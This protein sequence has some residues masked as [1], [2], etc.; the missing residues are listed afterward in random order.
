M[1]LVEN[2]RF[3]GFDYLIVIFLEATCD[4]NLQDLQD[5]QVTKETAEIIEFA[6]VVVDTSNLEVVYQHSQYVKPLFTP[7]TDFCIALT[8]ITWDKLENAGSLNEAINKLDNYIQTYIINF[9]KTFCFCTHGAWDLRI[10]LP[11]EAKEKNIDLPFYLSYCKLFDLK[12]EVQRWQAHHPDIILKSYSLQEIC[13][14]FNLNS[15]ESDHSTLNDSLTIVN[16][17]RYICSLAHS[18]VFVNPIDAE[19]DFSQFRKEQSKVI[20]LASLPYDVTQTELE[21]WF[22]IQDITPIALLTIKFPDVYQKPSGSGFAIF[23]THE[24][25]KIGLEMNG[26]V[27]CDRI[28]EVNPSSDRVIEAIG[29]I[30]SSFPVNKNRIRPGDWSCSSCQFHNF[31]SRKTCFRCNAIVYAT[32]SV[33][34]NSYESTTI[35]TD[36][37]IDVNDKNNNSPSTPQLSQLNFNSDEWDWKSQTNG[38]CALE[39]DF[40]HSSQ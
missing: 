20:H 11:K 13:S 40:E 14:V 1:P 26:K 22:S 27:L 3:S 34:I 30:L 8:K 38:L 15:S 23:S 21:S 9:N 32:S 36:T 5:I 19:A 39:L 10:Q 37:I 29:A 28:I 18:D 4:D 25:A 12:Q 24:D 33:K 31:A 6:W 16:I 7:L 35:T 2:A 17:I